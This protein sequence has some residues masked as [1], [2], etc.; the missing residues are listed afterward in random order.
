MSSNIVFR[1][2]YKLRNK[3]KWLWIAK[4]I[5]L[6]AYTDASKKKTLENYN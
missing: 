2:E 5:T 6:A 1:F 3:Q 4:V